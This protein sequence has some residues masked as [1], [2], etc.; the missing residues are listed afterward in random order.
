MA[1]LIICT[2]CWTKCDVLIIILKNS[3]FLSHKLFFIFPVTKTMIFVTL[4]CLSHVPTDS[5]L[6]LWLCFTQYPLDS[7][8]LQSGAWWWNCGAEQEVNF[9]NNAPRYVVNVQIAS[10]FSWLIWQWT[11]ESVYPTCQQPMNRRPIHVQF[12]KKIVSMPLKHLNS[13]YHKLKTTVFTIRLR[14]SLDYQQTNVTC[15]THDSVSACTAMMMYW[16]EWQ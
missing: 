5:L 4:T 15:H 12:G 10:N 16:T 14:V 8:R 11:N 9:Q 2:F 13:R 7:Y 1:R 3:P 6:C